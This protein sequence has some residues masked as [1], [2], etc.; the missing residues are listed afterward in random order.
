MTNRYD[1]LYKSDKLYWGEKPSK[2]CD[3]V[4]KFYPAK[5][6]SRLLVP[7]CGQGRNAIYLAKHG[8]HVS[9]FDLSPVG[10]ERTKLIAEQN[11]VSIDAFVADIREYKLP[12]VFDIIFSTGALHYIEKPLR[13]EIMNNYKAQ[14]AIGGIHV[15]SVLIN[16][17]AVGPASDAE[18]NAHFWEADEL[19]NHYQ[20]W[21]IEHSVKEIFDC[22]SGGEPH[23][24]ATDRI[25]ARKP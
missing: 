7:A 22:N 17:P 10:I 9:A 4:I 25:V 8:Y 14:T 16:D 18:R 15:L 24:H 23:Q 11:K 1:E 12:E 5:G 3:Q 20:D 19:A 6:K 13:S 2:T 21:K